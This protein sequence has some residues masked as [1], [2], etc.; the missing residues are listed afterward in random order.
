MGQAL[1]ELLDALLRALPHI[2]DDALRLAARLIEPLSRV[3]RV[4]ALPQVLGALGLSLLISGAAASLVLLAYRLSGR[5][6]KVFISYQHDRERLARDVANALTKASLRETLLPFEERADHDT[7]L[8]SIK[9]EVRSCDVFVCI[10]GSQP[11]FVESEVAMAFGL[12]KPMLFVITEQDS[13]RI[14]NTAKKGY[15][16][17]S[18]ER[19]QQRGFGELTTF[20][21]Y[22]AADWHS[23]VRLFTSIARHL[24]ACAQLI[25]AV[26]LV[27]AMILTGYGMAGYGME[28][29]SRIG[30]ER[31]GTEQSA[32]A[33][34]PEALRWFILFNVAMLALPYAA[35]VLRR[36]RTREDVRRAVSGRRFTDAALPESFDSHLTK[37]DLLA[38]LYEQPVPAV[39]EVHSILPESVTR[40][41]HSGAKP[42]RRD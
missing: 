1:V 15:P 24:A 25:I 9:A 18:F 41:L 13:P 30:L 38:V 3:V 7:L 8:D 29:V 16:I 34:H 33:P 2:S 36:R 21:S 12:E 31:I 6:G 32:S 35:F 23:T 42:Q 14:P 40:A 20:C 4:A 27:S 11:S 19:L 37:A 17:F 22:L 39:H 26:Y 5:R 10:P 28:S